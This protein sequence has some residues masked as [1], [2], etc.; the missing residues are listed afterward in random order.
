MAAAHTSTAQLTVKGST[1]TNNSTVSGG[2]AIRS[3]GAMVTLST[4]RLTGN[5]V[6]GYN[7]KG[8]AIY[9]RGG[10]FTV[11]RTVFV[12]NTALN[13]GTGGA[14]NI[15]SLAEVSLI[16]SS[17]TG[18]RTDGSFPIP[19][20]GAIYMNGTSLT[21]MNCTLYNNSASS[22]GG[23][24]PPPTGGAVFLASGTITGTNTIIWGNSPQGVTDADGALAG[25][26]TYCNLQ[27]GVG[28]PIYNNISAD[29]LFV[30]SGAPPDLHL[31]STSSPCVN[32]GTPTDAPSDDLD[33]LSRVAQPDIGAYEY[34]SPE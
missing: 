30:D 19:E 12:D 28:N 11:T 31:Q 21:L 7:P 32:A 24:P 20:G 1:F 25:W 14:I 18:N 3:N 26:A 8:G 16:N 4:S 33:G 2:G 27:D 17:F 10:T 6:N 13:N 34:R 15:A 22:S 23:G 5:L 29:P 9:A